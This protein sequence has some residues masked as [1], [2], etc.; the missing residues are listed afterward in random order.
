MRK[1]PPKNICKISFDNKTIEKVNVS[2]IFQDP[3][4]KTALPKTSIHF[5]TP[6]MVYTLMNPK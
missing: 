6:T 1:T 3:L 2:D 4:A 5:N